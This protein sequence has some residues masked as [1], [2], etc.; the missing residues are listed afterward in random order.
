MNGCISEGCNDSGTVVGDGGTTGPDGDTIGPDGA[1]IA[2]PLVGI[3]P[4]TATLIKG[5]LQF[6]GPRLDG[7][8]PHL[9]DVNAN[10]SL[11]YELAADGGVGV[12][13]SGAGKPNGNAVDPQGGL[14]TCESALNSRRLT[15]TADINVPGARTDLAT[16]YNGSGFNEP[17][18]VVVRGDGNVYFT[19]PRYSTIPTADRTSSRSTASR[20]A[21]PWMARNDSPSTSTSRTGSRSRRTEARS[22]SSTTAMG[23]SSLHSSTPTGR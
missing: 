7:H 16:T 23:A 13:R 21:P 14:V 6:A 2:D 3:S 19:D 4:L 17:N 22:S 8:A 9:S 10:P 1:V 15:R 20:R 18:D 11:L 12:F 5:G